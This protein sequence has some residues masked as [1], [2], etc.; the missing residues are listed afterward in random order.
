MLIDSD[1][2]IKRI[3]KE[4]KKDL[5]LQLLD[6]INQIDIYGTDEYKH[7]A[8]WALCEVID[9]IWRLVG[10]SNDGK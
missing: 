3:Y 1:E 7:G 8:D 6:E 4:G 2:A 9:I 10:E 5:A